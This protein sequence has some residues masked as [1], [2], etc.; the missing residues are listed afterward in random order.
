MAGFA[1][2]AVIV[3]CVALLGVCVWAGMKDDEDCRSRGGVIHCTT[4]AGY[5]YGKGGGPTTL[6]TCE[7]YWPDGRVLIR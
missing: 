3:L 4:S 5:T 1:W 2:T 7:C 6:T